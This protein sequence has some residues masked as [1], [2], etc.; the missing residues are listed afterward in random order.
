MEKKQSLEME[1]TENKLSLVRKYLFEI[2]LVVLTVGV[3]T[4]Q[5]QIAENERN[6][7]K[8][9]MEDHTRML[10]VIE[11]NTTVMAKLLPVLEKQGK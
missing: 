7:Q 10:L 8:Y 6:I 11:A 4:Q 3:I 1:L 9:L 5:R 2:A